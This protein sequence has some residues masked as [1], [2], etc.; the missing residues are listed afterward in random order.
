MTRELFL[1][2]TTVIMYALAS[3][4]FIIATVFQKEKLSF[5]ALAVMF[6]GFIAQS[7]AIVVRWIATGHGPYLGFYE[8]VS[9]M[10]WFAIL[11][12][13]CI[14]VYRRAFHVIGVA[15]V[16]IALIMLGAAM[17]APKSP[18]EIT[19]TLAS[20]WLQI[21]VTF[22]KVSYSALFL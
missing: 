19:P 13:I 3:G 17:F 4:L 5:G 6:I 9:M 21:H 2:W 16:P 12:L 18:L 11:M 10:A 14:V 22:A 15:V 7:L 1:M 20:V 8:V